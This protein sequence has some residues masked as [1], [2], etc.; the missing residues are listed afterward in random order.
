MY[1]S[2]KTSASSISA[3]TG[4]LQ[5]GLLLQLIFLLSLFNN[6]LQAAESE[7][8]VMGN[9]S[10]AELLALQQKQQTAQQPIILDVRSIREYDEGHIPGAIHMPYQQI[11]ARF[12][13]I[14][15]GKQRG[16]VVYCE[17]GPRAFR[18]AGSLLKL[19]FD[20]V[21]HLEGD[22]RLWRENQLPIEN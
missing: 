2:E 1:L 21:W 5:G 14:L 18:A 12:T 4:Y 22:M 7:Q 19:G 16:V 6:S 20:T 11:D 10:Q 15:A 3:K 8:A 13:E 9:I 17:A